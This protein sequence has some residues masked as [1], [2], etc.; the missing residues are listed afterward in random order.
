MQQ[1]QLFARGEECISRMRSCY[2]GSIDGGEVE[3]GEAEEQLK[4]KAELPGKSEFVVAVYDY[5][6]GESGDL[7]FL[8]NDKIKVLEKNDDGWWKGALKG[9]VGMFPSKN[10]PF[11]LSLY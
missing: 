8:Q 7:S 6:A 9:T 2:I 11:S 4:G 10:S 3:G 1:C 5:N